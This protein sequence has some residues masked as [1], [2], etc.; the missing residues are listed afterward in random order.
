[1]VVIFEIIAP[2]NFI[3]CIPVDNEEIVQMRPSAAQSHLPNGVPTS[4][5][6][7]QTFGVTGR[8]MFM[9][10]SNVFPLLIN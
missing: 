4:G 10:S 9:P 7:T 1:M 2:H 8:V 5:A 6:A 3:T